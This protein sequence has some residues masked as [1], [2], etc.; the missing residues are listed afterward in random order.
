MKIRYG[1]TIK[2]Q[3][4][5]QA[6]FSLIELIIVVAIMAIL[7]IV[8]T[9]NML[10]YIGKAKRTSDVHTAN[11]ISAAMERIAIIDAPGTS[12][13]EM[14]YTLA[15]MWNKDTPFPTSP[16]TMVDYM[17]FE[18]GEVPVSSF[19]EN[20]FWVIEYDGLNGVVS[21]I[22]LTESPS[23]STTYELYPD[24]SNYISGSN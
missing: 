23:S 15:C 2:S 24:G 12:A 14:T 18:L 7:M 8:I 13:G 10:K 11:E 22:Y 4:Y 19:N 1:R 6:G 21:R 17:F 16:S 5:K 3:N 9:P 20:Y